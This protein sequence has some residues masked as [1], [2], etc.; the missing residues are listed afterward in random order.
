MEKKTILAHLVLRYLKGYTVI[1]PQYESILNYLYENII[2]F[3]PKK[4]VDRLDLEAEL[5][6]Y[7]GPYSVITA[8]LYLELAARYYRAKFH[9]LPTQ[10]IIY[11]LI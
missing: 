6:E 7:V 10:E 9:R 5:K 2:K 4:E 3:L 8:Q 11:S 1:D